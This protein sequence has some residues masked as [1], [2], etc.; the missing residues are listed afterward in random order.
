MTLAY[1]QTPIF[2]IPEGGE[3]DYLFLGICCR[4]YGVG[5]IYA[6]SGPD[7]DLALH[8]YAALVLVDN[9]FNNI[10][11]QAAANTRRLGGEEDVKDFAADFFGDSAAAVAHRYYRFVV[12][13]ADG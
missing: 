12:L 2:R 6:E 8:I 3:N 5:Q 13:L 7:I 1:R 11:P 9:L 10:Q 4:R